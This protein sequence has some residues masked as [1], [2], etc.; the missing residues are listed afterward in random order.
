MTSQ[1]SGR[2]SAWRKAG[3]NT[4]VDGAIRL[5]GSYL[6]AIELMPA[7]A[8]RARLIHKNLDRL[9]AK[10]RKSHPDREAKLSCKK[11]CS[12]CCNIQVMIAEDEADLL[13]EVA[14]RDNIPLDTERLE[15]QA[16]WT[17]DDY[18]A[19][20]FSGKAACVFLDPETKVCRVYEERPMACR[21]YLVASPPEDCEPSPDG[22]DKGVYSFFLGEAAIFE[23]AAASVGIE[24]DPEKH[25]SLPA[26]LLERIHREKGQSRNCG[27]EGDEGRHGG[28]D[29]PQVSL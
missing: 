16:A 12:H 1:L 11:G 20:F 6:G 27:R 17:E 26:L 7:G 14:K 9:I 8:P 4:V 5:I 15:A 13:H 22:L 24:S 19:H 21:S 29:Q 18:P 3:E 28:E 25:R 2:L 10:D 23:T